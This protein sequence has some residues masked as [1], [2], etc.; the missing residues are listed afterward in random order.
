MASQDAFEDA[1]IKFV[2][3]MKENGRNDDTYDP[4]NLHE[5]G[6]EGL[7]EYQ[8][9][10]YAVLREAHNYCEAV[11]KERSPKKMNRVPAVRCREDS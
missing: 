3:W 7:L 6:L 4:T 11:K 9:R 10:L 2:L 8:S 5:A 1:K